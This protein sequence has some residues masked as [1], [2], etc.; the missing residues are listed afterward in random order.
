MDNNSSNASPSFFNRLRQV[1]RAVFSQYSHQVILVTGFIACVVVTSVIISRIPLSS[2]PEYHVGDTVRTDIMTP[3]PLT[4][5]DPERTRQLQEEEAKKISPVFRYDQGVAEQIVGAIRSEFSRARARFLGAVETSFRRRTLTDRELASTQ[6]R[7]LVAAFQPESK[8]FAVG[9]ELAGVWAGGASGEEIQARLI[10]ALRSVMD[11]PIRSDELA[12]GLRDPAALVRLVPATTR[13]EGFTLEMLNQTQPARLDSIYPL[14]EAREILLRRLEPTEKPYGQFLTSRLTVNCVYAEDLTSELRRQTSAY[15]T[16]TTHYDPRQ[17][18]AQRGETVTPHL[19]AAIDALRGHTTRKRSGRRILG[20][21]LILTALFLALWRFAQRT[22]IFSLSTIKVFSLAGLAILL[23]MLTVRL[24]IEIANLVG[25]RLFGDIDSPQAYQYAIPFAAAALLCVLLLEARMA[26]VVGFIISF[27]TLL[28][29][30]DALVTTYAAV[31]SIVAI[32]GVGR[33]QRREA[34]TRTGLRIALV[35]ALMTIIL[36]MVN[37][38]PLVLGP[39]AFSVGCGMLGG[40]FA[41]ALAAFALPAG[42]SL[43]D[44]LTDVKLLELS[45]AELPLLKRLAIEAP[46]TYQHSFI[47]AT[48]AEA[49]A[50]A[51]GA[52]ALLVRIG[53]YYHDVGKLSN[54]QMYVENQRSFNA[55]ELLSPDESARIIMQHVSE[56]IRLAQDSGLPSPVVDLIPQHHGTRQLHYFYTKAKQLA[57]ENGGPIDESLFRYP[58][59]K[60]QT[61]EAAI[62]MMADS[63]E[64]STRSLK[65]PSPENFE[66]MLKK[67][68]DLII[69]DG[70]LDECNLKM[71]DL[72]AIKSSFIETLCNI[73]HQRIQYPGFTERDLERMHEADYEAV[74]LP[75]LKAAAQRS[76]RAEGR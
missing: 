56:G 63:A 50:K 60:P 37:I 65:D 25:Y 3:V 8:S 35:N 67:V 10:V 69:S 29:T 28:L 41:A 17:V 48:L 20:L 4:V 54:P 38:Q 36:M 2:L 13:R 9:P 5:V 72:K 46:G 12:G 74:R 66:L 58:G 32:Y 26:L 62:V 30:E 21:M 42:E 68:F 23:Q 53:S 57:D 11:R 39:V 76:S 47:V 6:F 15:I 33:Y 45:N 75:E 22:R 55:H 73:H 49:A 40:I 24:G 19:K 44:I 7:R 70:Q 43:F 16:A 31:S 34:L 64:A 71:R 52:N 51:V 59:P 18:I 27:L 14:A 61:I 1:G